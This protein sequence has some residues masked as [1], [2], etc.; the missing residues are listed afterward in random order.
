MSWKVELQNGWIVGL[1]IEGWAQRKYGNRAQV[2]CDLKDAY[3]WRWSIFDVREIKD[4]TTGV[5]ILLNSPE[6][7][8][9]NVV[10]TIR[11]KR[12]YSSTMQITEEVNAEIVAQAQAMFLG[13]RA[14]VELVSALKEA[15][16]ALH[17]REGEE[18]A[19]WTVPARALR[20]ASPHDQ[21]AA[22]LAGGADRARPCAGNDE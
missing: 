3:S 13:W 20:V 8:A 1:D 11:Y 2:I 22:E 6:G 19:R 5:Q 9:G 21:R 15:A 7:L 10:H 14:S 17:G 18:R 12:G 16:N 4:L